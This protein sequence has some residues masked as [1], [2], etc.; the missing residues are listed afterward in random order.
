MEV[1]VGTVRP[2]VLVM[3]MVGVLVR[4]LHRHRW[5]CRR[6]LLLLM[7][8]MMMMSRV[9]SVMVVVVW[10]VRLISCRVL[11]LGQK[12]VLA[13][14]LLMEGIG[15]DRLGGSVRGGR[16]AQGTLMLEVVYVLVMVRVGI[17]VGRHGKLVGRLVRILQVVPYR[18]ITGR[19][20]LAIIVREHLLRQIALQLELI[21]LLRHD[22]LVHV[23]ALLENLFALASFAPID[24]CCAST[25]R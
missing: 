24:D 13:R 10:L 23:L 1:S 7:M 5:C 16:A 3:R 2:G 14:W 17:H 6:L 15:N 19:P 12:V 20:Q 4:M 11:P 25:E 9:V 8:R 22:A 18:Q 21:H